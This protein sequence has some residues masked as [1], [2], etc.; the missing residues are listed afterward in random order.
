MD[1]SLTKTEVTMARRKKY[2][3]AY[4]TQRGLSDVVFSNETID[5]LP[6]VWILSRQGSNSGVRYALLGVFD[7]NESFSNRSLVTFVTQS[8]SITEF[9]L[10]TVIVKGNVYSWIKDMNS[11]Y[12]VRYTLLSWVDMP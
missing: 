4:S 2:F 11:K 5:V 1:F 12:E 6:S 10:Q 3:I 7:V 8:E 9:S